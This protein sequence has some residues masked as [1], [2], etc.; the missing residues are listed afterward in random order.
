MLR[1]SSRKRPLKLSSVPFCQGLPGS[2]W[3]VS[4][5]SAVVQRRIALETNSGPLSDLQVA[6][7]AARA[8]E[9]REHVDD[10]A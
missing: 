1:H 3:A 8:D 6:R 7:G 10:A 9:P 4:M 5:P 2:M